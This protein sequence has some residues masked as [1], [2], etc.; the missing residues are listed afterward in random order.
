M[1]SLL[2]LL[3]P[4]EKALAAAAEMEKSRKNLTQ[5]FNHAVEAA[6]IERIP[7]E[8]LRERYVKSHPVEIANL[9]TSL[10]KRYDGEL[11]RRI[12][13]LYEMAA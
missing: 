11:G 4:K 2:S 7:D 3:V 13:M 6:I 1:E 5:H 8:K 12:E 9:K 10:V